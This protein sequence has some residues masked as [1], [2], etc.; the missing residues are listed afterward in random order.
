MLCRRPKRTGRHKQVAVRLN[1]YSELA[2][3]L[4]RQR[5]ADGRTRT[6]TNAGA[7]AGPE[8]LVRFGE[9][10]QAPGPA[11]RTSIHQHPVLL[12]D[13]LAEFQ[14]QPCSRYFFLRALGL[15]IRQPLGT[16][17]TVLFG[18][19]LLPAFDGSLF[20]AVVAEE[21]AAEPAQFRNGDRGVGAH[22]QIHGL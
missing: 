11:V 2:R 18:E 15:C 19:L 1:I 12:F 4:E 9:I 5:S 22:R 14:S 6:V 16:S 21:F 20:P 10:P 7:A 13:N 8:I 17:R 3:V